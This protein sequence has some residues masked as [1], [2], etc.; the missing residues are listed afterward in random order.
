[1]TR[2]LKIPKGLKKRARGRERHKLRWFN[3]QRRLPLE[4]R[5]GPPGDRLIEARGG[6]WRG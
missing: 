3:L 5:A 6:C 1:V 4:V 2:W